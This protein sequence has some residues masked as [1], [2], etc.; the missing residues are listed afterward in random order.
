MTE[1]AQ[2]DVEEDFDL[3][4]AALLLAKDEYSDL[5]I[6]KYLTKLDELAE[7]VEELFEAEHNSTEAKLHTMLHYL[8]EIEKF[9]GNQEDYYDP[10]NSFLND[11]LDRRL[12]IPITLSVITLEV[13]WRLGLPLVGVGFPGHFLIKY[14]GPDK[15][16]YIDPF[17]KGAF[18]TYQEC[19][20]R[21]DRLFASRFEPRE[22]FLNAITKKQILTRM[23]YNLKAIY[24]HRGEFRRA[25]NALDKVLILNPLSIQDMRDRGLVLFQL[26]RFREARAELRRYLS[27]LPQADDADDIRKMLRVMDSRDVVRP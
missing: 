10:R 5:D 3:A 26:E 27:I 12:G 6:E 15:E 17:S 20:E 7:G 21:L 19:R 25:L 9:R 11:C 22:E 4:R 24:I 16:R 8:F 18:L 23:L 13:G 2:L 14:A 1:F